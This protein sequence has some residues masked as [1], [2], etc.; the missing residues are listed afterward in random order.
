MKYQWYVVDLDEG[1]VKG[2]NDVEELDK[3]L[4][5]EQ[6]VVLSAQ[7]GVFFNG[8]RDQNEVEPLVSEEN[9]DEDEEDGS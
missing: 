3:I 6:Y 9:K 2:S 8:S 1:T 5:S 4:Q 7:H